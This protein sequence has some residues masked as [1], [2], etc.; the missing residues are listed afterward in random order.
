MGGAERRVRI[1]QVSTDVLVN[2]EWGLPIY[3]VEYVP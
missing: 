2:Y 1:Y 3:G